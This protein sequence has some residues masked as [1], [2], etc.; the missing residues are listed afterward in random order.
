[1]DATLRKKTIHVLDELGAAIEELLLTGV[2]TASATTRERLGVGFQEAGRHK[3]LR[4]ASTLR[5]VMEELRRFDADPGSLAPDRLA[6]FLD[7]AWLLARAMSEALTRGDD[8]AWSKL[9]RTAGSEPIASVSAVVLGVFKRHVPGAFSAFEL[10]MRTTEPVGSLPAHAPISTSF[11]FPARPGV[12]IAPETF[13]HLEQPQKFRAIDLLRGKVARFEDVAL[14]TDRGATRLML[15]PKG[16]VTVGAP[17]EAWSEL[18]VWDRE[19]ARE[20]VIA[21]Q[22]DPLALPVELQEEAVVRDWTLAPFREIGRPYQTAELVGEGLRYEVR[23]ES[24]EVRTALAK[25]AASSERHALFGLV[26][27][28]LCRFVLVPLALLPENAAPQ[29]ITISLD[30][31][32]KAALVRA[33]QIR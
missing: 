27:Y 16:R 13:L 1:M 23:C 5:I 15:S 19:V 4:L 3:L 22:P 20:R 33:M 21:Q 25:A 14:S 11:V 18:A 6:F 9:V 28:E 31:V 26:H 7:R 8:A 17:F 2:T 29:L 30:E 10:R 12:A 32:D 24:A